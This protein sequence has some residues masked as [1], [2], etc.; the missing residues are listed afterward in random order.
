MMRFG[1]IF[2]VVLMVLAAPAFADPSPSPSDVLPGALH[3]DYDFHATD[4]KRGE[5]VCS[6]RWR[7]GDD[8]TLTTLSGEEVVTE[9]FRVELRESYDGFS[10]KNVTQSWLIATNPV[11]NGKPD[12]LGN[13]NIAYKAEQDMVLYRAING[14]VVA[15]W[16]Y[17]SFA[18]RAFG[19]LDPVKDVDANT[20]GSA[21][22]K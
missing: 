14:R 20:A 22:V 15:C 13:T 9:R 5:K 8:G 21:P 3:G 12:C 7:F 17:N 6:E 2:P 19:V 16:P 1:A 10:K 18:L 4:Q 11:S